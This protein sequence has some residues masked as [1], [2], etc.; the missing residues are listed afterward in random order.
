MR[1]DET[2]LEEIFPNGFDPEYS[3]KL[4]KAIYGNDRS[5]TN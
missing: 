2:K 1:I 3:D 4:R 5:T